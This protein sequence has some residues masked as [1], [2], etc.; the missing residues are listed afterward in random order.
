MI[1]PR[2]IRIKHHSTT[3]KTLCPVGKIQA[4]SVEET[5]F[6]T[7]LREYKTATEKMGEL[8]L[9]AEWGRSKGLAEIGLEF[10]R[11]MGAR[12]GRG[13]YGCRSKHLSR[14][15]KMDLDNPM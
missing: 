13:G 11:V 5:D 9:L 10:R 14:S 12:W 7:P 3:T 2:E 8:A 6:V 1:V 15:S 4:I